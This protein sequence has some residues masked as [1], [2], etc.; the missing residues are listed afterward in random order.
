MGISTINGMS[1]FGLLAKCVILLTL[2]V[3]AV[4]SPGEQVHRM[5]LTLV[6]V[7]EVRTVHAG[8][9]QGA[10]DP[11]VAELIGGI[12]WLAAAIMATHYLALGPVHLGREHAENR[13][14]L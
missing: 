1:I 14:G 11:F 2:T 10:L 12:A 8:L 13:A 3:R 9:A 6:I 5:C 4:F 7:V